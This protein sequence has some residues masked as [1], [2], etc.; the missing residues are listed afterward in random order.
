MIRSIT[1]LATQLGIQVIAEGVE[2]KGELLTCKEIGC[3]LV[4]G[5]LIQHPTQ[6]TGEILREYGDIIKILKK[7]IKK[8]SVLKFLNVMKYQQNVQ[9]KI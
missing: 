1:D 4:Q 5:Y 7:S 3:H 2:T 6:Q 9:L 8:I